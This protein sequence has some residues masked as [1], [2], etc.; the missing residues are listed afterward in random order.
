MALI[1]AFS[2]VFPSAAKTGC[3][4]HFSQCI[5]RQ[6]QSNGLL[7]QYSDNEFSLFIRCLAALAFVLLD[8]VVDSFDALTDWIT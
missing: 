3:F 5:F 4:F 6:V 1:K 7:T 8:D 2:E